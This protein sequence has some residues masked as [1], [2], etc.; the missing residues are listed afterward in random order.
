[1]DKNYLVS[2]SN[3]L[4]TSS[5]DLSLEEQKIILTLAS[6]VQPT[7][8]EF[9]PYKFKI[10]DF[11]NLLNISTKTKYSVLPKITKNLIKKV[12]EIK[13]GDEYI[14][15]SWLSSAKYKKGSGEL[16]LMFDPNLKP[17]LLKLN[18]LYTSYKLENILQ[19][20]SKYSI[21]IY[22]IMKSYEFRK[23]G[24]ILIEINDLRR[25]LGLDE[26]QYPRFSNFKQ[27]ILSVAQEEINDKTDISL[28]YEQ[29]KSGKRV[30]ALKFIINACMS[31]NSP[32]YDIENDDYIEQIRNIFSEDITLLEAEKIYNA[33][34]ENIERIKEKYLLAKEQKKIKSLVPWI[35]KA[36][37]E[38][39]KTPIKSEIIDSFNDYEQRKYDFDELEKRLLGWK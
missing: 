16:T 17:Y 8:E 26:K 22:E 12:V 4:I 9:K 19:L 32:I 1:M 23:Q 35:I 31:P 24:S 3:T 15:L 34:D 10:K 25:M 28:D 7:D 13:E 36:L 27:K 5:Y 20:K 2:K 39:F 33:A 30:I 38:D 29:I 11:M 21:R 18:K 14:Q 37:K 6:M